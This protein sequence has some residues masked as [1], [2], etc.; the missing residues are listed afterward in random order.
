MQL[1]RLPRF[2]CSGCSTRGHAF[3]A[4][5]S[6]RSAPKQEVTCAYHGLNLGSHAPLSGPASGVYTYEVAA[7]ED[8]SEPGAGGSGMRGM[9]AACKRL[10]QSSLEARTAGPAR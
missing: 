1:D 10:R 3:L 9:R 8:G 6:R 5:A 2:S 4:A 7:D